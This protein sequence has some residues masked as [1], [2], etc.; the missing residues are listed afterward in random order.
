MKVSPAGAVSWNVPADV[1]ETQTDVIMTISDAAGQEIFHTFKLAIVKELPPE[2][3][4]IAKID[5]KLPPKKE[6]DIKKNPDPEPV[7]KLP[8]PGPDALTIKAPKL[9]ADNV[10]RQ[11]P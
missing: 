3:K 9:E 2:A 5:P 7:I 11:L 6:P 10:T 8:P 1:N 4:Q